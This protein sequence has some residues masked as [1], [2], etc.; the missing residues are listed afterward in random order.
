MI[1]VILCHHK[2]DFIYK[3]V[4]SIQSSINVEFEILVITSDDSLAIQGISGCFVINNYG[5]PAEKRNVGARLAKGEYLAFFDDDVEIEPDCLEKLMSYDMTYGKLYNMEHRNR[6]DEAGGYLTRTGFIWSRAGQNDIDFG[7]YDKG[8]YILSGKSASCMIR[9][10]IFNDVGGFDEDFWILGE[11]T[12]LAWRVWLHG[13]YVRFVP[14]A[15]AYHAFNTRFKPAT[16]YYT[17][18]RVHYNGC[19]NYITMLIKNME[20]KNLWRILPIHISIWVTSSIAMM[21]SGKLGQGWNILKGLGYVLI[22]FRNILRKRKEV[23]NRRVRTDDE[24]WPFIYRSHAPRG[25]YWNRFFRYIRIG[26]HG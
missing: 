15:V 7:Q 25:Y 18:K 24:L 22:N 2:G 21:L 23:Q 4:H 12:D 26:L 14:G 17:S 11:E 6:F 20:A 3:A 1:S 13:H 8:D 19:R 9:T 10:D 16:E 5:G